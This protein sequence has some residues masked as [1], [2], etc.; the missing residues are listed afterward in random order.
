[1]PKLVAVKAAWCGG[2]LAALYL[3]GGLIFS[4]LEREAELE[5]YARNRFFYQQMRDLYEFDHCKDAWFKDM[6][7]C[8][9][10]ADFHRLL[11][12]FFERSGNEMEDHAKW[13]FLGSVFFVNALVTTIGYGNLHPRTPGGQ[14]FSVVF[15]LAGI[16]VMAYTLSLVAG[17]ILQVC[18]PLF[19]SINE[20]S[21]RSV[22]L[23]LIVGLFI[24]GGGALFLV[25]ED[26]TFL[27]A[28]YFSITTLMTIG[29]GDYQPT[30]TASRLVAIL[31]IICGLG[32]AAS[33][34]AALTVS[35]EPAG[36]RLT[37]QL[38]AWYDGSDC[39][40]SCT[41]RAREKREAEARWG[42]DD[43]NGQRP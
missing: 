11:K 9:N 4:W 20:R 5:H 37:S 39:P 13:T 30:Y 16:P 18:V 24:L 43:E 14:F 32:V 10:Q 29:F 6:D 40:H 31:F 23:A 22:V 7:F 2:T 34:I 1:M 41:P 19:P 3:G 21:R 15:G 35:L 12:E 17:Y 25:L 33:F 38:G 42:L 8:K 28:C 26:W 27:E 36:E